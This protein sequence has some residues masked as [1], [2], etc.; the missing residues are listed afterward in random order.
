MSSDAAKSPLPGQD[1]SERI[2]ALETKLHTA[3]EVFA[4]SP[5]MLALCL[6]AIGLVKLYTRIRGI[7]TLADELLAV[8]CV[9]FL[10]SNLC[11]YL[12]I[13]A[14]KPAVKIRTERIADFVFMAA[15]CLTV[16]VAVLIV[17]QFEG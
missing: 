1:L 16:F 8:S 17:V 5:H 9:A 15:L 11:S 14:R 7:T 12:S 6:T 2:T 10:F 3:H 13:R 4:T